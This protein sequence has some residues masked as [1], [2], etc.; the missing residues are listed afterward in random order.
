MIATAEISSGYLSSQT[1][2]KS[3][4]WQQARVGG[5]FVLHVVIVGALLIPPT[6]PSPDAPLPP[7]AIILVPIPPPPKTKREPVRRPPPPPKVTQEP[8]LPPIDKARV[9]A[10]GAAFEVHYPPGHLLD[11]I[12]SFGASLGF[13]PPQ[14]PAYITARF[15]PPDWAPANLGAERK[16]DFVALR[17]QQSYPLIDQLRTKYHLENCTPF[18]LFEEAF[19]DRITAALQEKAAVEGRPGQVLTAK[20]MLS[21]NPAGVHVVTLKMADDSGQQH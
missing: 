20:V 19:R 7:S 13:S 16:D 15:R 1:V 6:P 9:D 18:V 8:K 10:S 5:S 12:T 11:V 4:R 17:I 2:R 14:R 21:Y 3:V